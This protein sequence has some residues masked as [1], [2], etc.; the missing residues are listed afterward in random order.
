MLVVFVG[1][2][3]SRTCG[4][5][6]FLRGEPTEVPDVLARSLIAQSVFEAAPAAKKEK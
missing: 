3:P 4:P 5:Y 6:F 1:E 2:S